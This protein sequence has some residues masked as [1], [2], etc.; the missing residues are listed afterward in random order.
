M[1][2]TAGA[3]ERVG[4]GVRARLNNLSTLLHNLGRIFQRKKMCKSVVNVWHKCRM[5]LC[6]KTGSDVI[7][8]DKRR[9]QT[10][11][12]CV[13][14]EYLT[15][16]IFSLVVSYWPIYGLLRV[17]IHNKKKSKVC[18]LLFT[19]SKMVHMSASLRNRGGW[20]LLHLPF[21]DKHTPALSLSLPPSLPP[22]ISFF[23]SLV[24]T[25]PLLKCEMRG[26]SQ[27][28]WPCVSRVVLSRNAAE[29]THLRA[30]QQT[31]KCSTGGRTRLQRERG[32]RAV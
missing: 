12:R 23:R 1:L 2:R 16:P 17:K 25:F 18:E 14:F 22:S 15:P 9:A 28:N 27:D 5:C 7:H 32:T 10:F 3:W 4:E 21:F 19:F 29:A 24:F 31:V 8:C 13:T 11:I 30:A 20:V 6:D 26:G